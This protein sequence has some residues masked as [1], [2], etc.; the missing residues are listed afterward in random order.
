MLSDLIIPTA[1]KAGDKV[2][3]I[4]LSWGGAGDE[5][6]RARYEAG[7]KQL[8]DAFS[9]QVVE[10]T[11]TLKG[12]D[13]IYKNPQARVDDLH[14]AFLNPDIK[15]IFSCIGGDDSVRLINMVDYD[16]IRNNPKVF[17]GYSDT[18]ATHFMCLKAGLRSFYGP[19]IMSGFAE[20]G[21]L[22]DYMRDSVAKT[23]FSNQMIGDIRN[24][25]EGWTNEH[26]KW[27]IPENQNI[28]R[29]MH[30]PME[31]KFIQG[32]ESITGRLIGGCSE[33]IS[34]INATSIWPDKAIWDNAILF[35]ENSEEAISS[36]DLSYIVRNLGA[37]GILNRLAGVL[38]SRPCGIEI[39]DFSQYDDTL[40][41]VCKEFGAT[42]M[43]IVT[44]MDFGHTDPMFVIPFGAEATIDPVK[45]TFTI[46]EAGC[47]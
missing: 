43:P 28:K 9:V 19:S 1:L 17:M 3:A 2:A 36:S 15:G 5:K 45:K 34:M 41:K 6:F 20:N 29:Q 11:N 42:K 38:F 27:E 21:G 16:I 7:K 39:D 8:Q 30:P 40:L 25:Q 47:R 13:F 35:L 46:N 32:K 14:E 44:R 12:S 22:H 26:L 33:L 37:Q 23:I 4:S 24:S 10:L 18:T 31:W